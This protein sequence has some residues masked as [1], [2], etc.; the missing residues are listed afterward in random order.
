[1]ALG[2]GNKRNL[3]N[4]LF[5]VEDSTA[6]RS[7]S[8]GTSG[9]LCGAHKILAAVNATRR[10]HSHLFPKLSS[11]LKLQPLYYLPEEPLQL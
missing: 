6:P 11:E 4:Y 5:R 1:M 7:A 2:S 3:L 9:Q 10:P 8:P